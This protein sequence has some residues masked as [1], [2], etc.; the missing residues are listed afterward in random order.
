MH[1]YGLV[2]YFKSDKLPKVKF[3][4]PRVKSSKINLSKNSQNNFK[5]QLFSRN[6]HNIQMKISNVEIKFSNLLR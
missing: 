6:E 3:E 5:R 1:Q 2:T 4:I